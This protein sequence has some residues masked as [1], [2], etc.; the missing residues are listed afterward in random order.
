MD[1]HIVVLGG[2][3]WMMGEVQSKLDRYALDLTGKENPKVCYIPTATGDADEA[4]QRFYDSGLSPNLTHFPL[5]KP[6]LNWRTKLQE[7]DVIYVGGGNTRSMLAIWREWGIDKILR[8]C[9]ENGAVLCGMSAGAICWFEHGIT[10]SNP[11]EYTVID[12]LGFLCG[13]AS[14]HFTGSDE[15]AELFSD[16]SQ[17]Y[18][19]VP[20]Y[21]ISNYAALHFVNGQLYQSVTSKIDA[22]VF[23]ENAL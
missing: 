2:G 15:K 23:I 7:Q 20:C 8:E 14:A 13:L 12:G 17:N 6:G 10:D 22:K 18:S 16:F 4:I 5:F 11:E 1:K 21:G 19:N 3:G 9:Y